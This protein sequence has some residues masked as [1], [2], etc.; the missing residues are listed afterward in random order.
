MKQT[1]H[2][3][4]KYRLTPYG[5]AIITIA[6][7]VLVLLIALLIY[8]FT[9]KAN[10]Q[11]LIAPTPTNITTDLNQTMN[12]QETIVPTI[13][14]QYDTTSPD[15][16]TIIANKKHPIGEYAP[17]DL[18]AVSNPGSSGVQYL[19]EEAAQALEVLLTDAKA[20]GVTLY[21]QSGYRSYSTQVS[22]YENYANR[23]G[24]AAAD[25]YSSR[26]GYSDHQTGLAMDIMGDNTRMNASKRS[27]CPIEQCEGSPAA[28]WLAE[29][30]HNYGFILRYPVGKEDITG[31][32]DEWWHYRYV[33]KDLA[34]QIHDSELTMEEFFNVSGGDY[35]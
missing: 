7:L 21:A 9:P 10:N 3:K 35:E 26:A 17:T 31:Y 11:D 28:L 24:Y 8:L 1:K 22:L 12:P 32:V 20:D 2:S 34:Q 33:G 19:R 30:A 27:D 6:L 29:N 23:D 4:R 18:V 13:S 25:K 15:S 16:L 14:P 5:K